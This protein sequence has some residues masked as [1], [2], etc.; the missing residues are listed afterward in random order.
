MIGILALNVAAPSPTAARAL[1]EYLWHREEQVWILSEVTRGRGSRLI[2]DVCRAGG[3]TVMTSQS[4]GPGDRARGVAVV[5]TDPGLGPVEGPAMGPEDIEPVE[6]EGLGTR[7]VSGLI[8]GLRVLGVYEA[9]SDPVRYSGSAQRARKRAWLERFVGH[10]AEVAARPGPLVVAGD[11]N[12]VDPDDREG[13]PYVLAE[14]REAYDR[15]VALGL[16]D[17]YRQVHG[18]SRMTWVDHSGVGCRYDHAFTRGVHVL[19]AGI[20]DAPRVAG[21][22][23]HSALW[24][25]LRP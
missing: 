23:D 24:L 17:A 1:L 15:I 20:D 11:L 4:V 6:S 18:G 13:L 14:E 10:V 19:D 5:V 8:A 12:I 16:V 25:R 9:A 21:H 3:Y 22:T 2:L 7:G